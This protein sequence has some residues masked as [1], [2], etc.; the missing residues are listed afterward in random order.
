MLRAQEK[1]L[2]PFFYPYMYVLS[3]L[4]HVYLCHCIYICTCFCMKCCAFCI[5]IKFIPSSILFYRQHSCKKP[6]YMQCSC[7]FRRM[8]KGIHPTWYTIQL[9]HDGRKQDYTERV[10]SEHGW[11]TFNKAFSNPRSRRWV[12]RVAHVKFHWSPCSII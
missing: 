10:F 9:A 4:L 8:T 5:L 11:S 6:A 12:Y 3:S 7:G 2:N 1:R